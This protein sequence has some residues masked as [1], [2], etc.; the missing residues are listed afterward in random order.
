[1]KRLLVAAML[2]VAATSALAA[3]VGVSVNINQPGVYGRIDIGNVPPPQ[4]IYSQPIFVQPAPIGVVGQSI[5]LH[6]PPGHE[7]HWAKHCRKYNACAQPVYFVQ[8]N[9]YREVYAP[10]YGAR[11]EDRD[12]R[13]GGDRGDR[14]DR[15][16]EEHGKGKGKGHKDK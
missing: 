2:A 7:K 3:D 4:L 16:G 1:M 11:R 6:V 8:D 5:Y 14:G 13:Q 10:R 15:G 12:D 9:W